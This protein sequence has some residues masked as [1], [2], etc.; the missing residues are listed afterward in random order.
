MGRVFIRQVLT[1]VASYIAV[2]DLS[3]V[4]LGTISCNRPQHGQ[5]G[6]PVLSVAP[7]VRL[8]SLRAIQTGKSVVWFRI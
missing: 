4:L 7:S 6:G 1:T 2:S 5:S 8:H 3:V